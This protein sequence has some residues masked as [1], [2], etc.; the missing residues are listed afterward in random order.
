MVRD[1]TC[2][3]ERP[4]T[5]FEGRSGNCTEPKTSTCKKNSG[6]MNAV[7]DHPMQSQPEQRS[8]S[9]KQYPQLYG[10]PTATSTPPAPESIV[11]DLVHHTNGSYVQPQPQPQ[12]PQQQQQS[13]CAPN[14]GPHDCGSHE[15]ASYNH[16]FQ[17]HRPYDPRS[18]NY[19]F[20]DSWSDQPPMRPGW[21]SYGTGAQVGHERYSNAWPG[22]YPHQ[23]PPTTMPRYQVP[24]SHH[25]SQASYSAS[26]TGSRSIGSAELQGWYEPP[27]Q[28]LLAANSAH[29]AQSHDRSL[30]GPCMQQQAQQQQMQ[31][32]G[33]C[34]GGL[35]KPTI[36]VVMQ[37]HRGVLRPI[38]TSHLPQQCLEAP[39]PATAETVASTWP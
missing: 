22:E 6:A 33:Y 1:E 27:P 4:S 13:Y 35:G 5:C 9:P 7:V 38:S 10:P 29:Y 16:R 17:D 30:P 25:A 8:A 28:S 20:Y 18:Y 32:G 36:L 19:R 23:Y 12:P 34:S 24:A 3:L 26:E 11:A 31:Y 37:L 14:S 39:R 2:V 15:W 21:C